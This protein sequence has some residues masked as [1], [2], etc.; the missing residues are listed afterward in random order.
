MADSLHPETTLVYDYPGGYVELY[1]TDR[2][3]FLR[4]IARN[5]YFVTASDL[6]PGYSITYP[7]PQAR[8]PEFALLRTN[9]TL[10]S[11]SVL[12]A[13]LTPSEKQTRLLASSRMLA[14]RNNK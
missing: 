5:P 2:K 3:Q 11:H 8:K 4:A 7:I 14:I 9:D 6:K 10:H 12:E 1:T 13:W